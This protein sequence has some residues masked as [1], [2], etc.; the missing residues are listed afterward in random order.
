MAFSAIHIIEQQA[1][2]YFDNFANTLDDL[3]RL[4]DET[5]DVQALECRNRL[6]T[7]YQSKPFLGDPASSNNGKS[8]GRVY[9][10]GDPESKP[11][12]NYF[13]PTKN[14]QVLLAD[15]WFNKVSADKKKYTTAWRD[16]FVA[17]LMASEYRD[18]IAKAWAKPDLRLQI[19][20]H[21]MGAL[22]ASGV[23][24]KKALAIA[25]IYYGTREENTKEV[26]T[27]AKYMGDSRKEYYT[28]W[29][30]EYVAQS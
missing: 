3:Q 30:K 9:M 17:D 29:I 21:V 10:R 16:K 6:L 14:L 27:L 13:A 15:E 12:I 28:T 22:M 23:F 26:K 8:E 20:G 4:Y 18:K 7:R 2:A 5:G 11:E 1:N 19:K 25:R 24:N